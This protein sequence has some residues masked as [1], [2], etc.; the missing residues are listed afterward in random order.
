M[1][2]Q[3]KFSQEDLKKFNKEVDLR[4]ST[5]KSKFEI[6]KDIIKKYENDNVLSKIARDEISKMARDENKLLKNKKNKFYH[7]DW[8]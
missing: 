8:I 7:H 1:S 6:Y 3:G 4:L 2:A 5:N